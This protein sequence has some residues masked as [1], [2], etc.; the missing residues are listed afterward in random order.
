MQAICRKSPEH[1]ADHGEADEGGDGSG[2]AFEVARQTAVAADPGECALDNPS[3]GQNDEAVRV[4][5]FD[6]LQCPATCIGDDPGHL[7]P[8]IAGI[9]EDTLD[10][11]EQAPCRTE[12]VAGAVA[13]LHVG[14][15]NADAQQEAER[16]N[17]DM[18]LA[19][20]DLLARIETLR[21][22]PRAPF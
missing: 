22:K 18:S 17:E 4:A 13:I 3:L 12:Q 21:V 11:G 15:L 19:P 5:A 20:G 6:D 8:L 10:E 14:G 2:V 7:W 16:I 9:G 1:D